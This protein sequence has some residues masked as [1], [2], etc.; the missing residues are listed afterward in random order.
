ME[1]LVGEERRLEDAVRREHRVGIRLLELPV[2][3]VRLGPLLQKSTARQKLEAQY[4]L[5]TEM[6]KVDSSVPASTYGCWNVRFR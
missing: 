3:I 5:L 4:K 6:S 2:P 1:D